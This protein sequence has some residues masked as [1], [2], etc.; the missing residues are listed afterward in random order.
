MNKITKAMMGVVVAGLLASVQNPVQA[1]SHPTKR[2]TVTK[3]THI[4][5]SDS[6]SIVHIVGYSDT[7]A[8]GK[9][10][11]ILGFKKIHG[12]RFAKLTDG[13]SAIPV[14]NTNYRNK[15]L[16]YKAKYSDPSDV[17]KKTP[18][19]KRHSKKVVYKED[20]II[21][22]D[23][24][25]IENLV[26]GQD[27][28]GWFYKK[29][30]K[31]G[32]KINNFT[33]ES[34]ADNVKV[35]PSHLT[36][37]Q[38][39]ELSLYAMRLINDVRT[40]LGVVPYRYTQ[41]AQDLANDVAKEYKKDNFSMGVYSDNIDSAEEVYSNHDVPALI[42]A[43]KKYG[44]NI[45]QNTI[46]SGYTTTEEPHTLTDMKREIYEG[47]LSLFMGKDKANTEDWI[48]FLHANGLTDATSVHIYYDEDGQN[49]TDPEQKAKADDVA[50][51]EF[52]MSY[53]TPDDGAWNDYHFIHFNKYSNSGVP[54]PW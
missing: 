24:Y 32:L 49:I 7:Y 12:K 20:H 46:E 27:D 34:K 25:T 36:A 39:K 6:G 30:G 17:V 14:A 5:D 1:A 21:L 9:K 26:K 37:D 4:Y 13:I 45:D 42:R 8:K 48:E 54:R 38:Q 33:P 16:N 28:P 40:K 3:R 52:A 2:I 53:S 31:E 50:N 51:K 23:A 44:L 43:A 41:K 35:D 10:V 19:K 11:Y 47:L 29:A 22:P 15:K 18:K